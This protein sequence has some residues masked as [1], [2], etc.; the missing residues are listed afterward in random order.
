M[1]RPIASF[2]LLI[3]L[4]CVPAAYAAE[5]ADGSR[6]ALYKR[7]QENLLRMK[8]TASGEIQRLER[9]IVKCD[10]NAARAGEIIAQARAQ[11]KSQA[12]QVGQQA[13]TRAL[14]AK[15]RN[16]AVLAKAR[17]QLKRASAAFTTV[18]SLLAKEISDQPI[19]KVDC[20][21][22]LRDWQNDPVRKASQDCE[23][24]DPRSAP[25]CVARGEKMPAKPEGTYWFGYAME[26]MDL[27]GS[28]KQVEGN[29][30]GTHKSLSE[31]QAACLETARTQA[32][33][34]GEHVQG[35][36]E[37]LLWSSPR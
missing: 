27:T 18:T 31:A 1:M 30:M 19:E 9:E 12:E 8:N 5:T 28:S 17:M 23:C 21:A 32:L 14:E 6:A 36:V 26:V 29:Y 34:R 37:C 2:L 33:A 25:V 24:F 4:L 7:A 13:R 10:Q 11:G 35:E 16:E 15:K 3:F 20:A 22:L